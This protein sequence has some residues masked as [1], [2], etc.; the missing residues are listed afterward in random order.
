MEHLTTAI[1]SGEMNQNNT[2]LQIQQ[3]LDTVCTSLSFL[4][5]QTTLNQKP[6]AASCPT[7]EFPT[8][9]IEPQN[10]MSQASDINNENLYASLDTTVLTNRTRSPMAKSPEKKKQRSNVQTNNDTLEV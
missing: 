6:L 9:A 5:Q 10:P 4:V 1:K 7:P 3:Q 2:I 8:R